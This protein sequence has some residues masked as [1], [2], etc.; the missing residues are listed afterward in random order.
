MFRLGRILG[1]AK[2]NFISLISLFT[3]ILIAPR[4]QVYSLSYHVLM[5]I[6]KLTCEQWHSMFHLKRF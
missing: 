5:P 2:V 3:I 6:Q 1:G 4:V